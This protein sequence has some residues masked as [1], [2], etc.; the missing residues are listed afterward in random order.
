MRTSII[1]Y[2]VLPILSLEATPYPSSIFHAQV[3]AETLHVDFTLT[4]DAQDLFLISIDDETSRLKPS[5]G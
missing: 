3:A 1:V 4:P 2:Y 5:P